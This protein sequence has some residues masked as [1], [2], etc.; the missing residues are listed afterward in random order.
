M[1]KV[2]S[3][4]NEVKKEW[5]PLVKNCLRYIGF[6]FSYRNINPAPEDVCFGLHPS[7]MQYPWRSKFAYIRLMSLSV[8]EASARANSRPQ[9]PDTDPA[10]TSSNVLFCDAPVGADPSARGS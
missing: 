3:L 2:D 8:I 7:P 9:I 4:S 6:P 10:V 1:S 5:L